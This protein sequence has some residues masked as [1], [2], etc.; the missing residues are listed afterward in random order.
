[1]GGVGGG[2]RRLAFRSDNENGKGGGDG[3]LDGAVTLLYA[4]VP[5]PACAAL[6]PPPRLTAFGIAVPMSGIVAALATSSLFLPLYTSGEGLA[7][8][9][10]VFVHLFVVF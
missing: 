5:D 3:R 4:C 8:V 9:R 7:A 1:M 10:I 2:A 6:L